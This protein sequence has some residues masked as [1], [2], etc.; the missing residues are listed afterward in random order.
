MN[1]K[2]EEI[3][4]SYFDYFKINKDSFS[5]E[6]ILNIEKNIE[7]ICF[8]ILDIKK[9]KFVNS[10]EVKKFLNNSL[11]DSKA[12]IDMKLFY[13][14]NGQYL[15]EDEESLNLLEKVKEEYVKKIQFK[16]GLIE[17]QKKFNI[18]GNEDKTVLEY[19]EHINKASLY[20]GNKLKEQNSFNNK[21]YL[22]CLDNIGRT[23]VR[24]EELIQNLENK[25]KKQNIDKLIDAI[26]SIQ[27]KCNTALML[28]E[29]DTI[30][31][32]VVE[33]YIILNVI[34]YIESNFLNNN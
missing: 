6:E 29:K 28:S 12:I 26:I 18:K 17:K 27:A 13:F 19:E 7:A 22:K 8:L 1:I 21:E 3:L 5:K 20:V 30:E 9:N 15:F 10:I 23:K 34:N 14:D 25:Y 32:W 16:L 11:R 31:Y 4:N 33:E 24:L 2:K